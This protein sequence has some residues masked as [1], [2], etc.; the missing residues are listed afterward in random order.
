MK[1][2]QAA[3]SV[4]MA[5]APTASVITGK[6]LA[7]SP[8]MKERLETCPKGHSSLPSASRKATPRF[9]PEGQEKSDGQRP[10][11]TKGKD[12]APPLAPTTKGNKRRSKK[13]CP[14]SSTTKAKESSDPDQAECW[15]DVR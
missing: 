4:S 12:V 8:P 11:S 9:F 15:Q 10:L 7:T 5:P 14:K 1:V 13:A 2:T 6:R 3:P